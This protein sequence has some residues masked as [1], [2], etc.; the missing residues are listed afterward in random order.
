[1][2]D[3]GQSAD[4]LWSSG[5]KLDLLGPVR[6]ESSA[7]DDF[8]PRARKTRALLAVLAL[9]KSA[10][11]RSRLTEL[12][13]GDRGEEQAKASLRQAL[14]E[15]RGLSSGGY[16]TAER[17]SVS[18]GPKKLTTDLGTI[19]RC[20]EAGDSH[21]LADALRAVDSPPLTTLDDITPELDD[22]LRDERTRLTGEI[23]SNSVEVADK[24]EPTVG[25]RI[26]DELERLDPLDERVAQLGIRSDI[27]AG[28][29]PAAVRRHTRFKARLKD[30]LGLEPS[31]ETTALLR[32]EA[33]GAGSPARSTVVP[34][35]S[36]RGMVA[37]IAAITLLAAVV[38]GYL[39]FLRSAAAATPTVAV[40][41]FEDLGR[42]QAYFA[43]GV[44][45]E[46]LN[47]LAHQGRIR[48]LGRFTAEQ[49]GERA[50]SLEVARKLGITHLLD[51]SI[52]S[53]GNRVLVI[54]RLTRVSDGAQLWS[55]RYDRQIGDIFTVQGDIAS[56]V[57]TRLTRSLVPAVA[58]AT[59]PDV[60]DRYLAARQLTRERREVTLKLA[61]KLLREAIARDPHYAPA[62]AELAQV[63]MLESD[64][65]T[66]YGS[67]PIA[68]AEAE[69]APFARRAVQL[70]PNLGD[71]YAALGFLSLNLD[72]KSEPYFRKA[73]ELSPQRPEFHRWHAETLMAGE[74]YDDAIKEFR[75]AVEIDPLWGLN[76]DHLI[77]AYYLIGRKDEA[78]EAARRFYSLSSDQRARM[79]LKLSLQKLDYDLAGELKT[80]Q[81]LNR[82]YANERQNS[83]NLAATLAQLGERGA[84]ADLIPYDRVG[85][86]VLNRDWAGLARGVKDL[87]PAFWDQAGFWNAVSLL[88]ETGQSDLLA[89][90][91]YRD[92]PLMRSRT[93]DLKDVAIP[94]TIIALRNTGHR[95]DA[96][97][98]FA[99]FRDYV[100]RMPRRGSLG[101]AKAYGDATIA[102]LTGDRDRAIRELDSWTRRNPLSV[103][104]I[105]AMALRYDPAFASLSADPRFHAIEERIRLAINRERAKVGLAPISSEAWISDPKA[106]LTK[107]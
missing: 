98:L 103:T 21:G 54:V 25:R 39:L 51:G 4:L 44:S 19:H 8:T 81:W 10:V 15:L 5:M 53:A 27:A 62:F 17:E 105:P 79:L 11:P 46:I 22:W 65:P 104:H 55:E 49:V 2:A 88:I 67:I 31:P 97:R 75:R 20:I 78:R 90:L 37:I 68:Q 34:Q 32:S 47:L 30:Q 84:A 82:T 16:L 99:S 50:D 36:R 38:A 48:V 41:P 60:Y 18:L 106:L 33:R 64:H 63:I 12:L 85:S 102:A 43:N 42:R 72:A 93:I 100:G 45:D 83:L 3:Q 57:A 96:D 9:A 69:A 1:M 86:A 23:V 35:R 26:A 77:G 101:D 76:Y 73:V 80:A 87:G 28:D 58:Q 89:N 29:R 95:A 56:A 40:L 24:A 107:N 14:Y 66:A 13:W 70:D 71:G 59:S 74:R 94:E 91:Y 61:D 7:G 6:L 52:R 92:R